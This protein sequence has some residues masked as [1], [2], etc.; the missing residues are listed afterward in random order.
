MDWVTPV[1]VFQELLMSLILYL[2]L[3]DHVPDVA[4]LQTAPSVVK[5]VAVPHHNYNPHN[6]L[7]LRLQQIQSLLLC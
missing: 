7:P 3:E 4:P 2:V 5:V 6:F 1:I